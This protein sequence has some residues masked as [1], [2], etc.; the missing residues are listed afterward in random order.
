MKDFLV[1]LDDRGFLLLG[2]LVVD[3][4]WL[5]CRK[6]GWSQNFNRLAGHLLFLKVRK[7]CEFSFQVQG[8]GATH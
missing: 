5:S 1:N 3:M 6:F 7:I 8:L 2:A 4:A